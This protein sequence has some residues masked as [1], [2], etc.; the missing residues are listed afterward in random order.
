MSNRRVVVTGLGMITPLGHNVCDN[1][2]ALIAG[3]SGTGRIT[4]FDPTGYDS[5]V[6]GEVK[7]FDATKFM[8]RKDARRMD[9]SEERRVGK[10]CA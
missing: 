7:G 3:T 9:R 10:E 1:W 6:A 5:Q 2:V 8:D 4:H